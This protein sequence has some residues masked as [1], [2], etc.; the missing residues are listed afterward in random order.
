M[1]IT[2]EKGMSKEVDEE[3]IDTLEEEEEEKKAKGRQVS[4]E[5]KEELP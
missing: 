1:K 2:I 3:G 5:T 4:E